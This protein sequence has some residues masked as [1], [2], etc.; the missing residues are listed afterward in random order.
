M[1]YIKIYV[2]TVWATKDRYPFLKNDLRTK[3]IDHILDNAKTKNIHIDHINGYH[4]HLHALISLD[5]DQS[6]ANTINLLKGES[7]FWINQQKMMKYKFGWQDEYFAVSVGESQVETLRQY[8]RNQDIHHQKKTFQQEY[9][10]FMRVYG[11][12]IG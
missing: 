4:E 3:V 10:E 5:A 7:S 12:G 1:S 2:H 8:I 6:I 9:D 11:F